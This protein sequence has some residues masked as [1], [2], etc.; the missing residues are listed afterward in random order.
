MR[1]L[2]LIVASARR[3]LFMATLLLQQTLMG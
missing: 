1:M 3:W 2:V